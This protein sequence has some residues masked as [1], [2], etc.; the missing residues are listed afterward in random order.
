MVTPWLPMPWRIQAT[1]FCFKYQTR[2]KF[3]S[4]CFTVQTRPHCGDQ[5]RTLCTKR[6]SGTSPTPNACSMHKTWNCLCSKQ[7]T[8]CFFGWCANK[9]WGSR[10]D[11]EQKA[12]A[13][14]ERH[15]CYWTLFLCVHITTYIQYIN[16]YMYSVPSQSTYSDYTLDITSNVACIDVA[17]WFN[18]VNAE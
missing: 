7:C 10:G 12:R 14:N 11:G 3:T 16:I 4:S 5:M 18:V 2:W 8:K 6:R 1:L 15:P 13:R 17:W 9:R